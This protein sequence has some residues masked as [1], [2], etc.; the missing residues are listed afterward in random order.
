MTLS[1]RSRRM[2]PAAWTPPGGHGGVADGDGGCGGDSLATATSG[3]GVG[4][5]SSKPQ[6]P[7]LPF[8]CRQCKISRVKC[9]KMFPC[10][11]YVEGRETEPTPPIPF[12]I[13]QNRP[14][15]SNHHTF[16]FAS[17][18]CDHQRHSPLHL[19]FPPHPL[20]P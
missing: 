7:A 2:M 6:L 4:M 1:I 9:D 10:S 19:S 3:G 16:A 20:Y 14:Y 13:F 18:S 8:P 17:S 12:S 5:G 15:Y 11:R